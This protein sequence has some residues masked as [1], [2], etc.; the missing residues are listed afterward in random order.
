MLSLAFSV[1]KNRDYWNLAQISSANTCSNAIFINL[2][3]KNHTVFG[4]GSNSSWQYFFG[5]S[6]YEQLRFLL[7][8]ISFQNTLWFFPFLLLFALP[9]ILRVIFNFSFFCFRVLEGYMQ[10]FT[11]LFLGPRFHGVYISTCK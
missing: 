10:A 8:F 1:T 11:L 4:S 5:V 9:L 3:I 6:A 2:W 7:L